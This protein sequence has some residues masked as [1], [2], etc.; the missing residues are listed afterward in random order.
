MATLERRQNRFRIVLR[1]NGKKFS[2]SIKTADEVE[3]QD[4]LARIN[5]GLRRIELGI[6]TPPDGADVVTF[7]FSDGKIE[8]PQQAPKVRSLQ[9]L[10]D[11]FFASIIGG[12]IE[13]ATLSCMKTH[14]SHLKRILGNRFLFAEIQQKDLR[15]YAEQRLKEKG[16]RGGKVSPVTIRK[17][18]RFPS[19]SLALGF[20]TRTYP[21]DFTT[22]RP[23]AA[24]DR[25][26]ITFQDLG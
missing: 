17:E 18:P 10:V 16:R 24:K 22:S 9:Q 5:D 1:L 8:N 12:A 23:Q 13:N 20:R 7:L 15:H 25:R 26:K 3:A 19:H 14:L 4:A 11:T 21:K 6:L 2:R